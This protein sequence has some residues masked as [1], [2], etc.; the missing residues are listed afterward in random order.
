MPRTI[1]SRFGWIVATRCSVPSYPRAQRI[2]P[3]SQLS[4]A[5]PYCRAGY[6]GDDLDYC[7]EIVR[8]V[9]SPRVKL[10][11]DIYHGAIMNGDVIRRRRRRSRTRRAELPTGDKLSG[12]DA[13]LA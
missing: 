11:F 5:P 2:M 9:D 7:G 6:Q 3:A 1:G 13:E 8:R 12:D 10:L 4:S